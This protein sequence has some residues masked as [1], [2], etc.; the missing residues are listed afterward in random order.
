MT[1]SGLITLLSYIDPVVLDPWLDDLAD[2]IYWITVSILCLAG[3][4]LATI[5]HFRLDIRTRW[6]R[7]RDRIFSGRTRGRR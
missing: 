5:I 3:L 4:S 2:W 7:W 6:R 1:T